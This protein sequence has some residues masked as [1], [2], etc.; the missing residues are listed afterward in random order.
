MLKIS[1]N[2]TQS[3]LRRMWN[4]D[5]DVSPITEGLTSSPTL[6]DL[7]STLNQLNGTPPNLE[8]VINPTCRG[9]GSGRGPGQ[10]PQSQQGLAVE[11]GEVRGVGQLTG[12][13]P[14]E[15]MLTFGRPWRA[16]LSTYPAVEQG[17]LLTSAVVEG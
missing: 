16:I 8:G 2:S 4:L 10:C 17:R 3:S 13:L 1:I 7:V 5:P 14:L 9:E 11:E 15:G 12:S 6:P